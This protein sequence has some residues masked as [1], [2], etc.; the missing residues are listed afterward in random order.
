MTT[1]AHDAQVDEASGATESRQLVASVLGNEEYGVP[2]TRVQE[3]IRFTEP[4]AMP[5]SPPH[6]GGV[7]NLRG[8]IIPVVDLRQRLGV[9]GERAE[10]SK[11]VIV[12]LETATVG[13]EV[14]EVKEVLTVSSDNCELAPQGSSAASADVIDSV[15]KLEGRLLMILDLDRLLGAHGLS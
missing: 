9:T 11:I 4:R 10:D 8:R 3:F 6:V 13:I 2:I 15:A 14:D 1:A 5:E 7:I 12:E